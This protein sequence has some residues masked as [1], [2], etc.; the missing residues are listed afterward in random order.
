VKAVIRAL[1][2][3][4]TPT[5]SAQKHGAVSSSDARKPDRN[6]FAGESP[7]VNSNEGSS[8]TSAEASVQF[9]HRPEPELHSE[10]LPSFSDRAIGEDDGGFVTMGDSG[11]IRSS[12]RK[13]RSAFGEDVRNQ[14]PE[15]EMHFPSV[16]SGGPPNSFWQH[17]IPSVHVGEERKGS[18]GWNHSTTVPNNGEFLSLA[19]D[20]FPTFHHREPR[21]GEMGASKMGH[22]VRFGR[23]DQRNV[24][25]RD[26]KRPKERPRD[27]VYK[28][29]FS[30][31]S[32]ASGPS[33]RG[34]GPPP[35]GGHSWPREDQFSPPSRQEV[36]L[37]FGI[38]RSLQ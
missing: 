22:S 38:P 3:F 19:Q 9:P 12:V 36:A 31:D 28:T 18:N 14:F 6:H 5:P 21:Q 33:S 1:S 17:Q 8:S 26:S 34:A 35:L 24:T 4:P 16:A 11:T 10:V 30:M 29:R 13:L 25:Y 2:S 27:G 23:E 7:W 15:P 32:V 20:C 37:T